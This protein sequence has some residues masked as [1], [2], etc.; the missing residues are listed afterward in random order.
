[1]GQLVEFPTADGHS[2]LV[3]VDRAAG[4]VTRGHGNTVMARAEESFDGALSRIQPAVSGVLERLS[5][6]PQKPDEVRVEFGLN[7]HAEAGAFIAA[8]ST[9]ANFTVTITWRR[10]DNGQ[11]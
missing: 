9:T 8:A 7:M 5:D 6:L 11:A 3:E 2:V 1:M 4:P 10:A